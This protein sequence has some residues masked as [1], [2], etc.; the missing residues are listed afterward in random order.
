MVYLS[1]INYCDWKTSKLMLLNFLL[2]VSLTFNYSLWY[3]R[4]SESPYSMVI[5]IPPY[6]V[7][8][9]PRDLTMLIGSHSD[10]FVPLSM[11]QVLQFNAIPNLEFSNLFLNWMIMMHWIFTFAY[12]F[13]IA[14]LFLTTCFVCGFY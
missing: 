8:A 12:Y 9:N 14:F 4:W 13:C 3:K 5:S 6:R 1:Q 2:G 10:W 7:V 11:S